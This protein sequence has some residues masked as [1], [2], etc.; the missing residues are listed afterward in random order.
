[1]RRATETAAFAFSFGAEATFAHRPT[2]ALTE[3]GVSVACGCK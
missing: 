3:L 2:V 1:M